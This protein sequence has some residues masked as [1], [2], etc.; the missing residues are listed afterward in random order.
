M[1]NKE[2]SVLE[3]QLLSEPVANQ[4]AQKTNINPALVDVLIDGLKKYSSDEKEKGTKPSQK[5]AAY[6]RLILQIAGTCK[7]TVQVG[8]QKEQ[9]AI[10]LKNFKIYARLVKLQALLTP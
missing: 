3:P 1:E 6:R 2:E 9:K 7:G 4:E 10:D 5:D 8:D